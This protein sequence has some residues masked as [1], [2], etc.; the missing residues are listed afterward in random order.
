MTEVIIIS[1]PGKS[2]C[3]DTRMIGPCGMFYVVGNRKLVSKMD[4]SRTPKEFGDCRGARSD[5]LCLFPGH[6]I[7]ESASILCYCHTQL[8]WTIA[9]RGDIR[10]RAMHECGDI[11]SH[12]MHEC[13]DIRS[14]A[15]V[16]RY[17]PTA[18]LIKLRNESNSKG[19]SNSSYMKINQS[20]TTF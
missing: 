12:A 5:E 9:R 13:N 14:H 4:I 17:I 10:S 15:I 2:L 8:L 3:R 11:R 20:I 6:P 7:V 19:S 1:H 18:S 16:P